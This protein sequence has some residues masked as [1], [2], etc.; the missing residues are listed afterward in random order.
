MSARGPLSAEIAAAESR[1]LERRLALRSRGTSIA[2]TARR[3]LASPV[4]LLSAA[5]AGWILGS[6][7]GRRGLLKLFSA[8]QLAL[9]ALSAIRA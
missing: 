9:G 4:A 8:L 2:L 5:G 7:T 6:R 1:V 3:R